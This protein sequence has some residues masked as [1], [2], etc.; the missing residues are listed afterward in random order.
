[1]PTTTLIS[2]DDDRN[3][4]GRLEQ[5]LPPSLAVGHVGSLPTETLPPSLAVENKVQSFVE[6]Y[7][8][9]S[10]GF[11]LFMGHETN[12]EELLKRADLA[13]YQAKQ[14][15]RNVIRAFV[16]KMQETLNLRASLEADLRNAK[17]RNELSLH[18]QVQVNESGHPVGAEALIRWN[19]TERGMISPA[20]FIPLAEETGLILPI[21]DWVL[22][23]G[24][25]TLVDWAKHPETKLLKLAVN[26][27]SRQL[28]QA[29]FVEQVRTLLTETG[30]NPALL[31]LEITESVILENVDDTIAK[32]YAIKELG[33]NFS[34]DD[35]GTGYSSL[36]YL[37]K[38]PLEQLKIDQSFV[39]NMTSNKQDSAIVRTILALGKHLDLNIIA[40]GVETEVQHGYLTNF[41]CLV[42]QG[43][44]FG[45][46]M[47]ADSFKQSLL[48]SN[49]SF[50]IIHPKQSST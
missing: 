30:A 29:N 18:Y 25:E 9:G 48:S 42:F 27:S 49:A 22:K 41:G 2:L 26:I 45:K 47:S 7:S 12:S 44:L 37:Q 13:M 3:A 32:M 35:F 39:K 5:P 15:G 33:V 38:L 11:V 46:P 20:E 17:D 4:E 43:Y 31:K 14:A 40:E 19:H 10:I 50:A 23:Q 16:P 36:S 1:L 28:N 34:M 8:T 21:G 24:C 6:H